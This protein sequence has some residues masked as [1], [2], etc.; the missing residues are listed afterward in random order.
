MASFR[1]NEK[2][3]WDLSI[4]VNTLKRLKE[5]DVD[6]MGDLNKM[7]EKMASDPILLC[8]IL[9]VTCQKQADERKMSDV[10]F[11]EMLVGDV[12]EHATEAFVEA[13]I[14]F[15]PARRGKLLRAMMAKGQEIAQIEEKQ[16]E[17]AIAELDLKTFTSWQVKSE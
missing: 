9:Y 8:D 6:L 14:N 12:I 15:I 10:D 5:I 11:G 7:L 16:V 1:D 2:N 17:K 4:T 13:L 3:I